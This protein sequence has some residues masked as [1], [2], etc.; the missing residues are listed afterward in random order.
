ME[1]YDAIFITELTKETETEIAKY[2]SRKIYHLSE[3]WNLIHID[4]SVTTLVLIDM[5]Q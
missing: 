2:Y 5:I 3:G 4:D 1:N